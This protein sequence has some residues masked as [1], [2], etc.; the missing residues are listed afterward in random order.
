MELKDMIDHTLLKAAAKGEEIDKLC[1]EAVKYG[2]FAVCVNPYYVS[3]AACQLEGTKVKV[4]AVVGFPLGST[5]TAVKVF[6]TQKAIEDGADEIDMVMNLGAFK[7]GEYSYV[8]EDFKAVRNA[9]GKERILKVIIE[10]CYLDESEIRKATELVLGSGAD[11][12]KTS[13]G[14]GTDGAKISDIRL[15][16]EIVG[17]RVGIKASGGIRDREKALKMVEAGATRIGA[18]ASVKIVESGGKNER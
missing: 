8:Q 10:T 14:F 9:A 11:F 3:R 15:I 6:E 13:T 1:R 4:A 5:P 7:D 17:N 2:F 16:K 18:S 12:V